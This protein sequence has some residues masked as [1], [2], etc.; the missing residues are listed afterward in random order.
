MD[1]EVYGKKARKEK[2]LMPFG[3]E[4]FFSLECDLENSIIS[5]TENRKLIKILYTRVKKFLL[6]F[7]PVPCH[8]LISTPF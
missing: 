3:A 7:I 1:K 4:S 5:N 6:P 8:H 2:S